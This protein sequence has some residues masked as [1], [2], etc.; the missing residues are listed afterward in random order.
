MGTAMRIF[1][2]KQA[3]FLFREGCEIIN[4][5]YAIETGN[6]YV[7][8]VANDLFHQKMKEWQTRCSQTVR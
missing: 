1:N 4:F 6:P 5:G 3:N 8:F 2:F 7:R